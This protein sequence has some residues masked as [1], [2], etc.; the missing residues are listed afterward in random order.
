M[1]SIVPVSFEQG[2]SLKSNKNFL[3]HLATE[4]THFLCDKCDK[5]SRKL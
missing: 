5:M 3:P 1:F 4:N 2:F